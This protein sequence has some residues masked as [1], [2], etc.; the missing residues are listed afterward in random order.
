MSKK[1]LPLNDLCNLIA[2]DCDLSP[3]TIRKVL[4]AIYKVILQQLKINS[5]ISFYKFGYFELY[6]RPSGDRRMGDLENG[7][8]KI[9][10]IPPKNKISFTPYETF[11][12]TVNENFE[13][14]IKF[15]K[16]KSKKKEKEKPKISST[17]ALTKALNISNDRK[18]N[19]EIRLKQY[20][21]YN[22]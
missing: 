17:E 19:S 18:N 20:K 10:Y 3:N 21:E 15:S 8:T 7:G 16:S 9:C 5:G 14:P 4:E 13:V 22:G 6:E 11:E 1:I 2:L 12:K